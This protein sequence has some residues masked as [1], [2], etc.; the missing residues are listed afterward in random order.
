MMTFWIAAF[1]GIA[2]FFAGSRWGRA[3]ERF[4]RQ[5]RDMRKHA[6]EAQR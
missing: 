3:Q 4:D 6:R 5:I 1:F 2:M